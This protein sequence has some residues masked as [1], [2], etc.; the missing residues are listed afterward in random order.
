M[1]AMHAPAGIAQDIITT[2]R[3]VDITTRTGSIVHAKSTA[4]ATAVTMATASQTVVTAIKL[5]N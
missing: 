3:K 4:H 1:I 5:A 2:H